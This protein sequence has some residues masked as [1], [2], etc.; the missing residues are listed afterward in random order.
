MSCPV[1]DCLDPSRVGAG[2]GRDWVE[3]GADR[4]KIEAMMC[5]KDQKCVTAG[6]G[7]FQTG[8]KKCVVAELMDAIVCVG[9]LSLGTKHGRAVAMCD[10]SDPKMKRN[11]WNKLEKVLQH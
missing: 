9:Y 3:T 6:M 2:G 7:Y 1:T 4:E 8:D 5:P 11:I 10:T